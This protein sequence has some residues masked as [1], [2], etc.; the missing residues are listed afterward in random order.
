MPQLTQQDPMQLSDFKPGMRVLY[1][2]GHAHGDWEHPD[3]EDG[4][5]TSVNDFF[6]FVQFGAVK[7][8]ACYPYYLVKL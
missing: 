2:P 4:V 8:N 1:I 7:E 3:C 6:V 5:V